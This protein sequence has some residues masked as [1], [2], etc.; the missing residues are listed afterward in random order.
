MCETG[1]NDGRVKFSAGSGKPSPGAV[2]SSSAFTTARKVT[3]PWKRLLSVLTRLPSQGAVALLDLYRMTLG[4]SL[5]GQCR[6]Y[7]SC[8]TYAR[9]SLL[10]YG[11]IKGTLKS[12]WRLARC[13]PFNPGGVDEP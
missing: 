2:G 7:P 13:N 10:K 3:P 1:I 4:V 8:S 6:F 11:L 9:R 12:L 5:G